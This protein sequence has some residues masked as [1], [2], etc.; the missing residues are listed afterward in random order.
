LVWYP[1]QGNR[2]GDL[3]RPSVGP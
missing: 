1:C 3:A 2:F